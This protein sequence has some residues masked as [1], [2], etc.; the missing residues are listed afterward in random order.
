MTETIII[1]A[2][3]VVVLLII[4]G[5]AVALIYM[6]KRNAVL[7]SSLGSLLRMRREME[8]EKDGLM[9]GRHLQ[10]PMEELDD[11][12]LA[13]AAGGKETGSQGTLTE[14]NNN[15]ISSY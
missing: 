11:Y 14:D 13:V 3:A 2:L 6:S 8:D 5:L 9:G 15:P 4:T 12:M 10:V 7:S 1:I